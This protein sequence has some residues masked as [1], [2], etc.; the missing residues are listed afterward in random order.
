MRSDEMFRYERHGM[1]RKRLAEL[2]RNGFPD[3]CT[4]EIYAVYINGD[5]SVRC[6]I[7]RKSAEKTENS[8]YIP[9]CKVGVLFHAR[10]GRCGR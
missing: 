10:R 9:S 2:L 6:T 1:L 4:D 5:N 7:G 3:M 8:V